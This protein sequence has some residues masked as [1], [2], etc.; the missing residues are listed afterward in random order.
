MQMH[1]ARLAPGAA[2]EHGAPAWFSF[3][4]SV[5][6]DPIFLRE[7]G[8]DAELESM[9]AHELGHHVLAPSTRIDSLKIRH[10]LSRTLL[11]AGASAN[12]PV[13]EQASLL[14]N[15]WTDL[16]VNTRL[17]QLQHRR[18]PD[19]EPGIIR[20]GRVLY[21]GGAQSRLWWLYCRG[22]EL[23]WQLPAGTL[24]AVEAPPAPP[25][26][27][28]PP[29]EAIDWAGGR[30]PTR[31]WVDDLS[32]VPKE[33]RDRERSWRAAQWAK[34]EA[35]A[36]LAA[37]TA[38]APHV[39]AGF[40]A[41]AVRTFAHDPV[42]GA[43][44]FGVI[45]APYLLEGASGRT[46][47][48]AADGLAACGSSQEPATAEE[49]GRILGDG[50]MHGRLPTH[51]GL[52]GA[53]AE[54]G[55][56]ADGDGEDVQTADADGQTLGVAATL[57]LYSELSADAVLAAWYRTQA[58]GW[59]KPY[60]RRVLTRLADSIPG[61][62]ELWELGD[63]LNDIDWA[64]TFRGGPVIP[65]I[66]TRKRSQL[67]DEPVEQHDRIDLDLYIDSSGSMPRPAVGSAAI[68]AGAI[69][70]LSILRGGGRV[71]VTSFSWTGQV[72][73]TDAFLRDPN[74][75][76]AALAYFFGSGTTF[77]LDLYGERYLSLSPR[78][79]TVQRH[80]VVLSD[81][82]LTS[83]FGAGQEQFKHIAKEVR[84][85]LTTGTLVLMDRR[86]AVAGLAAE[87]GYDVIYLDSM[88]DAPRACAAL[89]EVLRGRER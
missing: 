51:P 89:A 1:D 32:S 83:M 87:S 84:A 23:L 88:D 54:T 53:T 76:I 39:D 27:F 19:A 43:L 72:S 69:L 24:C 79:R 14:S 82:G 17:A 20:V 67:P 74:A 47:A 35:D 73:G 13:M 48:D 3:P 71:R 56:D 8:L 12:S 66:T 49:L 59:V 40:V 58:A 15:L 6:V 85:R 42:A 44:R 68:L 21:P 52:A 80:V 29:K 55:G 28:Q 75:L 45:A 9:F 50:R 11:A 36:A 65:G 33:R 25:R 62:D 64:V 81:D 61:P 30:A 86:R 46:P 18:H 16:L 77:P 70:I 5:T 26:V 31:A 57:R 22:Y 34:A 78:D 63:D 10:Q 37:A 41:D 2:A 38:T 4:P 7:R 60:R